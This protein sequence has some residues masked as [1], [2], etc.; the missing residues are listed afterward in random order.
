[1]AT[2]FYTN[3]DKKKTRGTYI[4]PNTLFANTEEYTNLEPIGS[5]DSNAIRPSSSTS[6]STRFTSDITTPKQTN[7]T[8]YRS[9]HS[10]PNTNNKRQSQ[11][12]KFQKLLPSIRRQTRKFKNVNKKT[13]IE[14]DF[15]IKKFEMTKILEFFSIFFEQDTQKDI[16]KDIKKIGKKKLNVEVTYNT[17]QNSPSISKPYVLSGDKIDEYNKVICTHFKKEGDVEDEDEDVLINELLQRLA[18]YNEYYHT[19]T[20]NKKTKK[21]SSMNIEFKILKKKLF[22]N[23]KDI[24]SEK[25]IKFKDLKSL[26]KLHIAS[27]KLN[28]SA[29]KLSSKIYRTTAQSSQSQEY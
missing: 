7:L 25:Q 11:I 1:M 10:V 27:V 17:T 28:N 29:Q 4:E 8:K 19:K 13:N 23:L 16:K 15:E 12:K 24:F 5:N 18:N 14:K 2:T 20:H 9:E 6:S 22:E 26:K 3:P 21:F